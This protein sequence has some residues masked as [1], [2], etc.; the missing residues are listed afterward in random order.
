MSLKNPYKKKHYLFLDIS[1][2]KAFVGCFYGVVF[3]VVF[4]SFLQLFRKLIIVFDALLHDYELFLITEKANQFYNFLFAFIA[5][6]FAFSLILTYFLDTPRTFLSKYNYKVKSIINQQRLTNW[7][8]LSWFSRLGILIS[9][10]AFGYEG[11]NFYSEN[12]YIFILFFVAFY[13][14]IWMSIRGFFKSHKLK[15]FFIT[16][17]ITLS[18]SFALSQIHILNDEFINKSILSKNVLY[19]NNIHVVK[20]EVATKIVHRSLILNIVIPNEI[21]NQKLIV[22]GK[23]I[24]LIDFEKSIS[25]YWKWISEAE[26]PFVQ[27]V[28]FVDENLEVKFVDDLK[29]RLIKIEGRRLYYAT[30]KVNS[31][32]PFYYKTNK[33]VG[34]YL[35]NYIPY[36]NINESKEVAIKILKNGEYSFNGKIINKVDLSKELKKY[37]QKGVTSIRIYKNEKTKFYE[38]FQVLESSKKVIN[39]LRDAFSQKGYATDYINLN[40]EQK[41][42]IREK[43][44]WQIIDEINE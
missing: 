1:K 32:E 22:D 28:L 33:G 2:R 35:Q 40:R 31:K 7:I 6:Y 16:L 38:Y 17:F 34:V 5:V 12:K 41:K 42:Y 44:R 26:I 25:K 39:E 27:Y 14:Q 10:L 30:S 36:S 4:Y 43:Y 11:F 3:S 15:W 8:F 23:E 18:F 37:F 21:H 24:D 13:G 29:K 20:S 19:K 9:L